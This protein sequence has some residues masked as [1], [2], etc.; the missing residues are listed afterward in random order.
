MSF[1][2]DL[3][4]ITG[5]TGLVGSHV[6]ERARAAGLRTRALVRAASE[7]SLLDRW[8][9]EKAEGELTDPESLTRAAR[10]VTLVVHCA[11]KVGDWGPVDEYR[12]VNVRG[13][14]HLLN[15][16]EASGTLR[17]F[18]H[19]SS[20]GVYEG[21]DHHGTDEQVEPSTTGLDGYT[22]TKVE[23]EK[24]VLKHVR[25]RKLPATI[26]RPGFIYGPRD[27]SV[28]PRLL[29]RLRS[30]QV[31]YLGSGEQLMNNT[32]VGNLVDVIFDVL[33]KPQTVGEVYNI[34]DGRLVSKR[35]FISTVATLA[36][37]PVPRSAV[38]LGLARFLATASE[39][40][41]RLL[42]KKE[43]PLLSNA[44]FKFMGLN[45]DFSIEKAKRDLAY[46]PRVEFHDGMQ[47]TID[48]FR[49][50]QKL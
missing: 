50:Q 20:L 23:A 27:R 9:V 7:M 41:Y 22:L 39:R 12:A 16:V 37:Y 36:G 8:G 38:P 45:L 47:Q 6:A 19:I 33:D 31:K 13:L 18:V 2:N 44:R 48:W 26:L 3:L 5:A 25:D 43:A 15:A 42:G 1:D 34:T 24:L 46:K 35:D 21:R 40:V 30:G 49:E 10:G 32:Y 17:R 14:E 4:L 28:L 29:E 11:A